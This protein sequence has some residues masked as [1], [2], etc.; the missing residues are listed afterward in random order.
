VWPTAFLADAA[1]TLKPYAR[2]ISVKENSDG[3]RMRNKL[4]QKVKSLRR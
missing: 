3:P 4:A 2:L 1:G